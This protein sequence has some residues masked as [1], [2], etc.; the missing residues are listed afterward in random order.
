MSTEKE[1]GVSLRQRI[2][3]FDI[4][5]PRDL[6]SQLIREYRNETKSYCALNSFMIYRNL[7]VKALHSS[8]LN[9]QAKEISHLASKNWRNKSA[10]DKQIYRDACRELNS[11][12]K[13]TK[14]LKKSK[15]FS[16]VLTPENFPKK[17]KSSQSS[18]KK[19]MSE[20]TKEN[21]D[22]QPSD[23]TFCEEPEHT[24]C[25]VLENILCEELWYERDRLSAESTIFF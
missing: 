10:T 19:T 16:T 6:I 4:S 24:L 2:A 9:L 7:L 17:T 25:E 3:N 18:V 13:H 23:Q 14:N 8:G 15:I 5:N 12:T 21:S 20:K 1:F 22:S 11:F